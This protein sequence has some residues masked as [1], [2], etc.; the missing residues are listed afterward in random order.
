MTRS[1]LPSCRTVVR[2][3]ADADRRANPARLL[4]LLALLAAG[5]GLLACAGADAGPAPGTDA[6]QA[7]DADARTA[8]ALPDPSRGGRPPW[9]QPPARPAHGVVFVDVTV[10]P[11]DGSGP[12]PGQ[13]VRVERD[14]IVAIDD[15]DSARIPEKATVVDGRGRYLMPGLADMHVHLLD[16][17]HL[18]LYVATGVTTV[19]NMWG[20]IGTLRLRKAID[21]GERLGPR[22]VSTGA[23]LDG[24]PPIWPGSTVADTPEAARAAVALTAASGFEQVK[25]YNRL[26]RAAYDAVIEAAAAHDLPVV[27]HVPDRV[28]IAHA[29][30]QRQRSVEHL[31]GYIAAL[32]DTLASET[33]DGDDPP[34]RDDAGDDDNPHA[35]QVL[36]R[37]M[38]AQA[39]G[40]QPLVARIGR[41]ARK[42]LA[43]LTRD[44]GTWNVPTLIVTER[45]FTGGDARRALLQAPAMRYVEP[46]LRAAWAAEGDFRAPEFDDAARDLMMRWMPVRKAM[47]RAL[48]D[49][50]APIL[51]GT[52]APNP[53]VVPGFAIHDELALLVDAGLTPRQVLTA[54]TRD[55]ARFLGEDDDWGT[56][57]VGQRADL[58]L[59]DADPLADVAHVGPTHQ[60]G[61]L[62]AGRWLTRDALRVRLDALAARHARR[63]FAPPVANDTLD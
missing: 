28:G 7:A 26:Q 40:D 3:G 21:D 25:V 46:R 60:V 23:I 24:K 20:W 4:C 9:L 50:G 41:D 58:L 1:S 49:A 5:A 47:T 53:L 32:S 31:S 2:R 22:I 39:R 62:V 48:V 61:V 15:V 19:R 43:R 45:F 38:V 11:M 51:V 33:A 63:P 17:G 6:P 12:R 55:A 18:L 10:V 59:L 42:R 37:R 8:D 54:A 16:A 30:A 35:L 29:L 27:G 52:D 13:T 56:V 14:R 44:A 34:D 57:R 36:Q